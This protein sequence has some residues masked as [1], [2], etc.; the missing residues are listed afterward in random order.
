ML[1]GQKIFAG[2]VPQTD[3]EP[4]FCSP[5]ESPSHA[6][7]NHFQ[8]PGM[9]I[10][11]VDC[12]FDR[13]DDLLGKHTWSKMLVDPTS[14]ESDKSSEVYFCNLKTGRDVEKKGRVQQWR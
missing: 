10:I 6:G 14:E 9:V 12:E 7:L 11:A 4:F 3:C 13:F 1:H 5:F 2:H 8:S